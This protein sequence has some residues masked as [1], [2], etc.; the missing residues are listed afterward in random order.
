MGTKNKIT[1]LT[2]P[3]GHACMPLISPSSPNAC[4]QIID[5]VVLTCTRERLAAAQKAT[6]G[7][8]VTYATY[9]RDARSGTEH[10][11][12]FAPALFNVL[13][14]IRAELGHCNSDSGPG[15]REWLFAIICA[16]VWIK[17][18]YKESGFY[19]SCSSVSLIA[20]A[21]GARKK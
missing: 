2:R 20:F 17:V 3:R 16:P 7:Y 6:L 4:T 13:C 19:C 11:T 5:C 18:I 15:G 21:F 9:S 14:H 12:L 10:F 8:F 1:K